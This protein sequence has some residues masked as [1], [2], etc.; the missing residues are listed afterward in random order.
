MRDP[1]SDHWTAARVSD[2]TRSGHLVTTAWV[3]RRPF[4]LARWSGSGAMTPCLTALS[5]GPGRHNDDGGAG[6]IVPGR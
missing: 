3:T 4:L 2:P 6:R 5:R 1:D